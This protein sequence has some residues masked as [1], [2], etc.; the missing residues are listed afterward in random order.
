[1]RHE[2]GSRDYRHT[3]VPI[4]LEVLIARDDEIG[5]GLR[6]GKLDERPVFRVTDRRI[7]RRRRDELHDPGQVGKEC[8][9]R[10]PRLA[11]IRLELRTGQ[12]VLE[13]RERRIAHD[14]NDRPAQDRV[15]DFGE[16]PS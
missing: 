9:N 5:R 3:C 2:C 4:A 12:Y 8:L 13:F 10:H 14:R 1:M 11:K 6:R 7:A 16:R 15:D